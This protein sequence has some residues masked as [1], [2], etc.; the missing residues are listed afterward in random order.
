MN[1]V[2]SVWP[3]RYFSASLS[4]SSNSRSRIG[5][6]WPGTSSRTSGLASDPLRPVAVEGSIQQ[7]YQNP[8]GLSMF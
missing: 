4:K 6:T 1:S 8:L 2:S 5:M 3:A 7:N